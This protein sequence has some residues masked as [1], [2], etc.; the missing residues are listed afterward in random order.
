MGTKTKQQSSND[1]DKNCKKNL[2]KSHLSQSLMIKLSYQ[3]IQ[4]KIFNRNSFKKIIIACLTWP[5]LSLH[6]TALFLIHQK[7][8]MVVVAGIIPT[9]LHII[10][11]LHQILFPKQMC[12]TLWIIKQYNIVQT[13]IQQS[14]KKWQTW[15]I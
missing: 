13:E 6:K 4:I 8:V 1:N 12:L 7:P 15:R 5:P 11:A 10:S 3:D 14:C 9:V 2:R